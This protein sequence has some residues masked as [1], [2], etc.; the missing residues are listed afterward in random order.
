MVN[1]VIKLV[2]FLLMLYK[3]RQR[4]YESRMK[5]IIPIKP[6]LISKPYGYTMMYL[7]LIELD[8]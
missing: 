8:S 3:K 4:K 6:V 2:S 5:V 7:V 1:Y